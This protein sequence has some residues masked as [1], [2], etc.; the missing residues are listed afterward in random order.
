MDN[1]EEVGLTRVALLQII[2]R[3]LLYCDIYYQKPLSM[4]KVKMGYDEFGLGKP[5]DNHPKR[6][7]L[8][9]IWAEIERDP[10]CFMPSIRHS[11]DT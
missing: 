7:L 5:M 1:I 10:S 6:I 2:E 3:V 11:E 4:D 9:L 8:E